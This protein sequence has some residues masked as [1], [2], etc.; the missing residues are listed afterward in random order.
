MIKQEGIQALEHEASQVEIVLRKIRRNL[1]IVS[2]I[3]IA[4]EVHNLHFRF[5]VFENGTT[6]IGFQNRIALEGLDDMVVKTI[7]LVTLVIVTLRFGWYAGIFIYL[8]VSCYILSSQLKRRDDEAL[9][10]YKEYSPQIE[11]EEERESAT[12]TGMV[13]ED[14]KNSLSEKYLSRFF[15]SVNYI[16]KT[17]RSF[18]SVIFPTI[19]PCV[20]VIVAFYLQF[21]KSGGYI[22]FWYMSIWNYIS[23]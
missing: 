23:H 8:K 18:D 19:I 21:D 3:C 15:H 13:N 20:V 10:I 12:T 16:L 7:L 2:I 6:G 22:S 1:Y 17:Y 11:Y 14:I 4:Y 5:Q 9:S